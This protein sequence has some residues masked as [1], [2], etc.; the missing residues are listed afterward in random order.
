MEL[1]NLSNIKTK[2]VSA[3]HMCLGEGRDALE[4]VFGVDFFSDVTKRITSVEDACAVMNINSKMN[5]DEAKEDYAYRMI[6]S[7]VYALNEG[8]YPEGQDYLCGYVPT[9]NMVLKG[10]KVESSTVNDPIQAEFGKD[11]VSLWYKNADLAR[12][13]AE[14]AHE[15]YIEL[16]S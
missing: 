9:F 12:Y 16:L 15:Y 3:Y 7:V 5:D 6:R 2:A 10:G 13:G 14:L 8:W 1:N 4:K 11:P